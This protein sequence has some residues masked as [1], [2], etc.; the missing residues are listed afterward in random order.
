MSDPVILDELAKAGIPYGHKADRTVP[1]MFYKDD[2]E[3]K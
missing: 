3:R 1:D 2:E